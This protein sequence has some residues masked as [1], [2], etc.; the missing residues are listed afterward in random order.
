MPLQIDDRYAREFCAIQEVMTRY[1]RGCDRGDVAAIRSCF[2]DD[3]RVSHPGRDAVVG[4]DA[5]IEAIFRPA[6]AYLKNPD[7]RCRTHF[8]GNFRIERLAG[9]AAETET[10]VIAALL[11]KEAAGE[12]A[13][14]KSLRYLDRFRRIDGEWRVAERRMT[15]DWSLKLPAAFAMAF[16]SRV[17]AP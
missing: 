4:G 8:M 2:A 11:A 16:A 10:Y 3:A 1:F 12:T 17:G 5:V 14:V 6:F 13:D 15:Q 7:A 9:D